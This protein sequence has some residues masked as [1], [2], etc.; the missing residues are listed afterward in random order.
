MRLDVDTSSSEVLVLPVQGRVSV[1]SRVWC[2]SGSLLG[3]TDSL[4]SQS[5]NHLTEFP[6]ET[7]SRTHTPTG[8]PVPLTRTG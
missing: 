4:T 1:G 5:P 7:V 2:V 8:P 6:N 3:S